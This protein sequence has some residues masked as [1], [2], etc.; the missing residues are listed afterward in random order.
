MNKKVINIITN[1]VGFNLK[2]T[3]IEV[4]EKDGSLKHLKGGISSTI[5][6]SSPQMI[7]HKECNP[8]WFTN[9]NQSLLDKIK[10]YHKN[11]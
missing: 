6:V 4:V 3:I 8:N 11:N 7:E 10:D 1:V 2:D 5:H 9:F